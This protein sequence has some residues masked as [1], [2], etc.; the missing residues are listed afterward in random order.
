MIRIL[1]WVSALSFLPAIF[2]YY[3]GE[4]A[5]FPISSLEMHRSGSFLVQ[6]MYGVNVRHNP[7]FNWLIMASSGIFGWSHV[8][9]VARAIAI[10]STLGSSLVLYRLAVFLT[11]DRNFSLFSALAYLTLFDVAFYRGWLAYVDPLFSFF[12]FSSIA[13]AWVASRKQSVWLLVAA[14][15]C[16]ELAFLSK[17]LTAYVF[18]GISV[19]ILL[20]RNRKFLLG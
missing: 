2:F 16:L 19:L 1:F 12:V 6:V 9:E 5:I 20:K 11:Q 3:V 10:S 17:A 4:E 13:L 18:Y 15:I 14:L 7:L 8:L